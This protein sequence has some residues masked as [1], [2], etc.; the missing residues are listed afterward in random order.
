MK[1]II[2]ILVVVYLNKSTFKLKWSN[3]LKL[4]I[5]TKEMIIFNY[6]IRVLTGLFTHAYIRAFSTEGT[7]RR[8][9]PTSP[10][11]RAPRGLK[12]I[13]TNDFG[14]TIRKFISLAI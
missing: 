14:L 7:V 1:M 12:K 13:M 8:D 2:K 4:L 5:R 11:I 6:R 3:K 10:T 9:G